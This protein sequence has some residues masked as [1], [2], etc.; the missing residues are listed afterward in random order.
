M[1][2]SLCNYIAGAGKSTIANYLVSQHG[3]KEY[4]L[5]DG[6]YEIANKYFGMKDK[7]RKLLHYVGEKLRED[8][9]LLWVNYTLN[10]IEED[11]HNRVVITDTRKLLEYSYL[12]E[13]GWNNLMVYCDQEVALERLEKRD[14]SVDKELVLNNSLENQLRPLKEHMK[15]IDNDIEF[16]EVAKEIDAYIKYLEENRN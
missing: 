16:K 14:G 11:G 4:A 12:Q 7:N 13:M 8:Y 3:F 9:P 10:R 15:V 1:K 6:I 5:A 2:V